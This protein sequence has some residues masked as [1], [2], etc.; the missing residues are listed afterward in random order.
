VITI[1]PGGRLRTL[2][3]SI[4]PKPGLRGLAV[5]PHGTVY[6]AGTDCRCL[7][8]VTSDG[9]VERILTAEPPWA[10]T[11]V[12]LAGDDVLVL[13]FTHADSEKN[14]DW[15]PRVRK[16]AP[17]GKVTTLTTISKRE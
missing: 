11:E 17:D 9:K 3:A 1:D 15:L 6:A 12:A 4:D 8:K 2:V 10:P 5:D 16:L 14:E 13:E 7:V